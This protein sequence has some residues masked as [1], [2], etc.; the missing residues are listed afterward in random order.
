MDPADEI[1]HDFPP[2]FR[3]YKN[4]RVEKLTGTP[5]IAPSADPIAVV[6]S[7]DVVV[8][9]DPKISAR[10]YR[11]TASTAGKLPLLIYIHGGAFAIESAFSTLYHT[12]LNALTAAAGVIAVS[13]EYRLA[14]EDPIPA[15]YD[16][17]W[18]TLKWVEKES[19]TWI[20]EYAD[21]NRVYLA[22][23]S[24]GA[25]IAH[26]IAVRAGVE[27][28]GPGLK[29]VGLVLVHPYFEFGEPGK[30]WMYMCPGS[31]GVNDPRINPAAEPDL[32]G[33]LVCGKVHVC[34]ARDDGLKGRGVSYY[35]LLKKSDWSGD[36][37]IFETQGEDHVFHL[38]KPDCEAANKFVLL[39]ASFF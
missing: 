20:K 25:N 6:L 30:L 3:V 37:D 32:L 14:P 4:N 28:L 1:A 7:K 10:L 16:D 15:C 27:G 17:C 2:F 33:K 21:L 39:L 9:P 11:P 31:S 38:F 12:H 34:V 8:S 22:G 35:E 13:V 18:E 5:F 26:N 19:D 36:V 29:I 23:D 24:A